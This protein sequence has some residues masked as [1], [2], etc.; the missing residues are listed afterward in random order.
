MIQ[1]VHHAG[2]LLA[3]CAVVASVIFVG[4]Y[5]RVRWE[6]DA[7]GWFLIQ[8]GGGFALIFGFVAGRALSGT[9]LQPAWLEV[10]RLVV[11]GYCAAVA[12]QLAYLENRANR[13]GRDG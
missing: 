13:G 12:T 8:L 1:I 7:H 6:R 10:V 2:T 5:M 4:S 11:Y 3:V 9:A